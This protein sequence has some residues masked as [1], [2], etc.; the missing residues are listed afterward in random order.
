MFKQ[1]P[2]FNKKIINVKNFSEKLTEDIKK[3]VVRLKLRNK[4]YAY[5]FF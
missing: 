3:N 2:D 5:L 4:K 1:T